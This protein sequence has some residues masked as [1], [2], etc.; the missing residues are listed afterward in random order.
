MALVLTAKQGVCQD[1]GSDQVRKAASGAR[2]RTS[3]LP[4]GRGYCEEMGTFLIC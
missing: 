1:A 2:A 4:G 3:L